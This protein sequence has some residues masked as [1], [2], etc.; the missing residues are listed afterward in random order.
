MTFVLANWTCIS[1]SLSQGQQS[2][3]PFGQVSPVLLNAPNIFMY[4]SASDSAATIAAADYFLSM[5]A[6]LKVGD[7]IQG[8]ASDASFAVRVASVSSLSVTVVSVGL[9]GSVG[10]ANLQDGAVTTPKIANAAV[11]SDQINH[12]VLQ[13]AQFAITSAEFL[14]M[15]ATPKGL[16]SNA[17]PNTLVVVDQLVLCMAYNTTAYAGGGLVSLEYDSVAHAA[18]VLATSEVAGS[19]FAAASSTNYRFISAVGAAPSSTSVNKQVFLSNKTAAFT[20]GNSAFIA[21]VWYREVPVI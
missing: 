14:G 6:S 9:I 20:T 8:N 3:V 19:D 7:W 18:G 17:G 1:S 5:Y 12:A 2:V 13:Y 21:H 16:L 15:Y 4:A 11:G 10:T